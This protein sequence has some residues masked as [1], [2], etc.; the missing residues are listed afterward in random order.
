MANKYKLVCFDL[1]GTLIDMPG[2]VWE[3]IHE[4]FG[5][6]DERD[7]TFED[8]KVGRISYQEWFEADVKIWANAGAN[9]DKLLEAVKDVQLHEGALETLQKIKNNGLSIALISGSLNFV[10]EHIFRQHTM[11]F[12][13]VFINKIYF[14]EGGSIIGGK[15]NPYDGAGKAEGLKK[16][17][18]NDNDIEI[19]QTAGLSIAFMHKSERLA[20]VSNVVVK[21][22]NLKAILP[23]I[24]PAEKSN[25]SPFDL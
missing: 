4:F 14:G 10:F 25:P 7:K 16:I 13:Y 22:N 11:L 3:Q 19:A 15:H 21:D 8:Y 5:T 2:H 1:D 23:Y 12:D 24:L 18:D 9:K 17:G 20:Q 6:M